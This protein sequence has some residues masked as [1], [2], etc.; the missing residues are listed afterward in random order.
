VAPQRVSYFSKQYPGTGSSAA[1]ERYGALIEN[2]GVRVIHAHP[3]WAH[4]LRAAAIWA[5]S[6]YGA[7]VAGVARG[8]DREG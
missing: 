5:S 2:S 4:V 8:G 1:Q 3:W 6:D 7:Q